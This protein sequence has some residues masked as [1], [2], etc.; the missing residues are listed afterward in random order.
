MKKML[1]K[2]IDVF[3]DTVE[4]IVLE[5]SRFYLFILFFV[6]N[7]IRKISYFNQPSLI[8][9]I[10]IKVVDNK[11]KLVVT[12]ENKVG[13]LER[14]MIKLITAYILLAI[15]CTCVI[16]CILAISATGNNTIIK[17]LIVL[18]GF[19][20]CVMAYHSLRNGISIN[21]NT[22]YHEQPGKHF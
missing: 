14:N 18:L 20:F 2:L 19:L 5:L 9:E 13:K 15:C 21:K 10:S 7:Q 17:Y 3:A 12:S 11:I 22:S 8:E 6:R 1:L 16:F 4:E